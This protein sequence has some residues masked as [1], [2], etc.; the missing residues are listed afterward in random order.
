MTILLDTRIAFD[1][2]LC[3]YDGPADPYNSSEGLEVAW[4]KPEGTHP[5]WV[6]IVGPD[7]SVELLGLP[8]IREVAKSLAQVVAILEAAK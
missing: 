6:S 4:G 5:A 2:G 7:G 3:G 8:E 1:A